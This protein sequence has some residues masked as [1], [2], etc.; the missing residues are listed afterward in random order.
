MSAYSKK[1]MSLLQEEY[2]LMLLKENAPEMSLS[3]IQHNLDLMSESELK[4]I[5]TVNERII[6]E[7]FGGLKNVF[8]AA[9]NAAGS[10][11]QGAKNLAGNVG[12]IASA[13][14]KGALAAGKQVAQ[15]VGDMYRTGNVSAEQGDVL[16]KASKSIQE[17]S[18]YLQQAE[19]RGLMSGIKGQIMNLPLKNVIARLQQAQQN[20]KGQADA[21]RSQGFTG[22]AG[23][24]AAQAYRAARQ[25]SGGQPL[26]QPA[27]TTA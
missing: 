7:F 27:P 16:E 25:P 23:N 13:A 14:G 26:G 19:Q 8:G 20:A 11:V 10:A 3:Q 21:S 1:D 18:Q 22:G 6:N 2:S 5:T 15:N 9:K 24:A 17:L 4:Y 12:N